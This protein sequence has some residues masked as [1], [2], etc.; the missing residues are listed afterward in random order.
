VFEISCHLLLDIIKTSTC[1][2]LGPDWGER[3]RLVA[4]RLRLRGVGEPHEGSGRGSCW[5][6]GATV[7]RGFGSAGRVG[8][9][10]TKVKSGRPPGP[11]AYVVLVLNEL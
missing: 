6:R 11:F 4:L 7:R 3:R 5:R 9:E 2:T 8:G 10:P 1:W